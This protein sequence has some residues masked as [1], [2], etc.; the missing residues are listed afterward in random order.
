VSKGKHAHLTK[1]D[2]EDILNHDRQD[3]V[4]RLLFHVLSLCPECNATGGHI[5]AAYEAGAIG[6]QFSS[7]DVDLFWSRAGAPDLF[8]ELEP[9]HFEDQLALLEREE[10]YVHWGLV[11][12]LCEKSREAGLSDPAQAVCLAHLAVEAASRLGEWQPCEKHWLYELRGY[13]WA[14]LAS[15]YR[16]SGDLREAERVQRE[17]ESWWKKGAKDMGDILGYEPMVLSLKASLRK[18]QRRFKEA[19]VLLDQVIGTYLAGD[20]ETQDF[21]LAGRAFVK[22]AKVLEE[23]GNLEEALALLREASP[24]VDPARE[25][26]L[27]LCVQHNLL[28]SLAKLGRPEEA[29]AM[30][31]KVRALSQELGNNLDLVRLAW[32][33]GLIYAASGETPEAIRIL[34]MVRQEFVSLGV[35]FDAAL[36]TLE[37]AVLHLRAGETAA[38]AEL[39]G[40]MIPIFEAQDVHREALAALAVF[41]QAAREEKATVELVEK[42]AGYLVRARKTPGLRFEER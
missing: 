36:V 25:P 8:R 26:R 1:D 3:A 5:L 42:I 23:M 33:E 18:D 40:E 11:E 12:L 15:A 29:K 37:L 14:H 6:F 4:N 27:L 20:P 32:S 31:P 38:V 9:L 34:R 41:Q 10:R 28:D 13:A 7:I 19:L 39:A 35:G 17:S 16:V 22:K 24:L 21:H 2:L 30:L